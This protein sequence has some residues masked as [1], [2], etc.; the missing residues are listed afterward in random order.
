MSL[1]AAALS[2]PAADWTTDPIDPTRSIAVSA[3]A[4]LA[5][6]PRNAALLFQPPTG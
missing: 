4:W 2:Q 5:E 1:R 6:H 3:T